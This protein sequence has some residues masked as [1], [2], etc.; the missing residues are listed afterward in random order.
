[1]IWSNQFIIKYLIYEIVR[2]DF[3]SYLYL[4]FKKNHTLKATKVNVI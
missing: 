3:E 1:M 4:S 2:L